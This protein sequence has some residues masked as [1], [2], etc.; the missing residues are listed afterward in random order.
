MLLGMPFVALMFTIIF[1]RDVSPAWL[2]STLFKLLASAFLYIH[3]F[4]ALQAT[5]MQIGT[6]GSAYYTTM[7]LGDGGSIPV[8]SPWIVYLLLAL[9]FSALLVLVSTR[10]LRPEGDATPRA[11]AQRKSPE[12][13]A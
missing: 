7:D 3:P 13:P 8:P 11:P 4:I 2:D 1:G 6:G 10:M 9:L 12:P 5:A